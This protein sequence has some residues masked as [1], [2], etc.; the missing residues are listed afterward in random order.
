MKTAMAMCVVGLV[1]VTQ[2]NSH[3]SKASVKQDCLK[4]LHNQSWEAKQLQRIYC[5]CYGNS[6]SLINF[7]PANRKHKKASAAASSSWLL[8][9]NSLWELGRLDVTRFSAALYMSFPHFSHE[10]ALSYPL[11]HPRNLLPR[12][13][14]PNPHAHSPP[15]RFAS[16]SL[17]VNQQPKKKPVLSSVSSTGD[18]RKALAGM[19]EIKLMVAPG[20]DRFCSRGLL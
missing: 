6:Q 3:L 18:K 5:L 15:A 9:S 8:I 19:L 11:R 20:S 1:Q 14:A 12:L 7:L 10:A 2:V 13:P 17:K 4:I 16:L